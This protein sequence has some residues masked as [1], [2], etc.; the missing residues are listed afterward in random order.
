VKKM[1]P[2]QPIYTDEHGTERFRSNEI[3]E[4]L[5]EKG[6]IDLNTLARMD[7]PQDS[8]EQFAQLIG[9]SVSGWSGLSYVTNDTYKTVKEIQK[10]KDLRSARIA[11]LSETLN[12]VREHLKPVVTELYK[13]HE[14]DLES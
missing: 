4:Y 12:N 10:G 13:I 11:V 3:V 8:W 6:G 1:L 7:F 14:D 9:Y 5:L 2:I